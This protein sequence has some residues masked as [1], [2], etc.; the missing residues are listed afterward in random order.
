MFYPEGIFSTLYLED[1]ISSDPERTALRRGV[2]ESGCIG[3]Q[4]REGSLNI[5]TIFWDFKK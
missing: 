2:E 5:K 3:L 4:Q 1:G